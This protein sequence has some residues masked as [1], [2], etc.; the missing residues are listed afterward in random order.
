MGGGELNWSDYRGKVVLVDFWATWC[1]PC[2][3][4]IPHLKAADQTFRDRGF[5][6]IGISLDDDT[7][8]LAQFVKQREIPW[9]VLNNPPSTA[10]MR[11]PLAVQFGVDA[12]PR[13]FLL[14]RRGK[15]ARLDAHGAELLREIEAL[16][17]EAPPES[18]RVGEKENR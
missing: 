15:L 11:H 6:V 17:D 2:V 1:A 7:A 3:A 9:P 13:T 10:G 12:V 16:L 14:D 18:K 4:E 8:N 5:R